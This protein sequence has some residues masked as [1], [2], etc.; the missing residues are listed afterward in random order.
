M[1]ATKADVSRAARTH[2]LRRIL[3]KAKKRRWGVVISV[4]DSGEQ[5]CLTN[6]EAG[7]ALKQLIGLMSYA[8]ARIHEDDRANAIAYLHAAL[9]D[10]AEGKAAVAA[11]QEWL[12]QQEQTPDAASRISEP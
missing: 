1:S 7:P 10:L 8:L 3:T 5:A 12:D 11:G 2:F 4:V 9:S 6:E